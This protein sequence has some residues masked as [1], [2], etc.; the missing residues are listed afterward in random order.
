MLATLYG[1]LIAELLEFREKTLALPGA[2]E[3]SVRGHG[4]IVEAIRK[5]DPR[6]ARLAMIEHLWVLYAEVHNAA[7][8]RG[9]GTVMNLAPR[10]AMG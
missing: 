10:D 2:P 6:A 7:V 3:R 8:L 5:R 9:H 1:V 4:E